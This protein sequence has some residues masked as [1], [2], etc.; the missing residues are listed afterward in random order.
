VAGLWPWL[1]VAAA[2]AVHGLNPLTGW[3]L[4]A[5]TAA[6]RATLLPLALGHAI[7]VAAVALLVASGTVRD[8]APLAAGCG[9]LLIGSIAWRRTRLGLTVWSCGIASLHGSGLM[10]VP[11]LVPLCLGDAP[12]REITASG[13]LGLGLAAVGV[14][15]AAMLA[16]TAALS[17]AGHRAGT[18]LKSAWISI[19]RAHEHC[20]RHAP[21]ARSRR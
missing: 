10:L 17:W 19:L 14:H 8:G 7:A 13:S 18:R 1:A 21:D 15:M 5:C 6:P 16:V 11:A 20:R 2:G 9:V 4:A 3:G 12:A